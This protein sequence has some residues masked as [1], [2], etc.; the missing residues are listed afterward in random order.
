MPHGLHEPKRRVMLAA[1]VVL[2][3]VV[4]RSLFF[5]LFDE[6][7]FDSDQAIVGLMAKHLS[8][9]R[10]FPLYFYGQ[11]YMLG[12]ESWLMAPV[13]L[14][15]G[16]SVFALR[17][18]MVLINA[19]TALLL[20]WLLRRDGGLSAWAAAL[21][22]SPFALAPFITAAH[23]IEAQGGNPEPFAW[24]LI[25][26]LLRAR[27]LALG[28][29]MAVAFL[30]R[31]FSL[32]ALPALALVHLA[33]ARF[34]PLP[35]LRPWALTL[36]AFVVTM[37]GVNALKPYSD[38]L[39]PGSA[40]QVVAVVSR[41]NVRLLLARTNVDQSALPRRFHAL[42]AEYLPMIV[43]LDGFRPNLISIASDEHV[44]WREFLP[45]AVGLGVIVL[46]CLTMDLARRRDWTRLAFPVY[47]GLVGLQ[48][49]VAYALTRELS[50]FTF[51]YG[52]LA[53]F[54]PVAIHAIALQP[55]R[56]IGLRAA[57]AGLAGLLAAMSLV[58]HATVLE[59]SRVAPPRPRYQPLA[60]RL[61][62]RGVTVAWGG[63]WRAYVVAFMT[64]ERVIVASTD[65]QRI[66]RY[67]QVGLA[68]G[69]EAVTIQE[70]PCDDGHAFDAVGPWYLCR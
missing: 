40:G 18:T 38:L 69:A 25:A 32:Y 23:L 64:H 60:D 26:W 24:V 52:L 53:L 49:A 31:E 59:H 21:A 51:R 19:G 56:W 30:H 62:A 46:A 2:A 17:L 7:Y 16:P 15:L 29:T 3:A 1:S 65:L 41:D 68:A 10:A 35:L 27:P 44:G 66:R 57:G 47:L 58:D 22:V 70:T 48:A 13:F 33:E 55:W 20:W 45:F 28:A 61:E 42:G 12:V 67:Q 6:S 9:G 14:L 50:M 37:Q 8:E 34:R 36:F 43:G 5:L 39:G 54:L 4:F 63:Y 11:E